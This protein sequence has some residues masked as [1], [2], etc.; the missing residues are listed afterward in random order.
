MAKITTEQ[1]V[2]YLV[3]AGAVAEDIPTLVMTAYYESDFKTTAKNPETD[4]IGLF[5]INASSFYDKNNEPDGTL[6]RFFKSTGESLSEDEFEIALEDPQY[7]TDFAIAYLG[8]LKQYSD[9]FPIVRDNDMDPFSAWEGYT[10]Y[11]KP[12]LNGQMP[13]GRGPDA[14]AKKADVIAGINTFVNSF[15]TVGLE[16]EEGEMEIPIEETTP[17][18]ETKDVPNTKFPQKP[19]TQADSSLIKQ[20]ENNQVNQAGSNPVS[21]NIFKILKQ[22]TKVGS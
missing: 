8:D 1:V 15:Y 5:Q 6:S 2:E 20:G 4:A 17:V 14:A 18:A 19:E 21:R 9:Q 10:D 11:V 16:A 12:Y 22:I 13:K 7:N 3:N